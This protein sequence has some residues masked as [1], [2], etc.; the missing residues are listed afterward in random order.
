MILCVPDVCKCTHSI[1]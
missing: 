1:D